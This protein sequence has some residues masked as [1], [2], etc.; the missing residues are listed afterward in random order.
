MHNNLNC[1]WQSISDDRVAKK[2]CIFRRELFTWGLVNFMQSHQHP[3]VL[4]LWARGNI[5]GQLWSEKV[6]GKIPSFKATKNSFNKKMVFWE[7]EKEN[8]MACKLLQK[9]KK[10]S[11]AECEIAAGANVSGWAQC[12]TLPHWIYDG[13]DSFPI[14]TTTLIIV[15]KLA[16]SWGLESYTGRS[17]APGRSYLARQVNG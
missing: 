3:C 9:K 16:C 12:R 2:S 4:I 7:K 10:H 11:S 14:V 5:K 8:S 1:L 15:G 13:D 17:I 6:P